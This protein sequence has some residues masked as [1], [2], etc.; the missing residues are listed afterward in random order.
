MRILT[1]GIILSATFVFALPGWAQSINAVP[2]SGTADFGTASKAIPNVA[3]NDTING[4]PAVLSTSANSTVAKSGTWPTDVLLNTASGAITTTP[5]TPIGTYK[6]TYK[7]CDLSAPP[8]CNTAT[9][10]VNVIMSS[11]MPLADSG[12]AD[13]GVAS[14]PIPNL[15]LNDTVNARRRRA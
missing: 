9:D 15:A 2:D 14:K 11:I 12:M 3:A 1:S 7:L 8:N 5:G 10:T 13:A 6:V 4:V